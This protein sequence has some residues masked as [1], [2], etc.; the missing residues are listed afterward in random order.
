MG[1]KDLLPASFSKRHI[2]RRENEEKNP[3]ISLQKEINRMFDRFFEDFRLD[4]FKEPFRQDFPKI[5]VTETESDIQV[6]ADLPGLDKKDI[7]ISIS[8]NIMTLHGK[9]ENSIEE[10]KQNYY[11]RELSY[12]SFRREIVLP[13]EVEAEKVDASLNNG[14]LKIFVPKKVDSKRKSKKIEIKSY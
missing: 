6:V 13:A 10:K 4:T 12:G 14:I 3:F 1:V 9:K 7:E 5:D 11:R 2:T 8:D